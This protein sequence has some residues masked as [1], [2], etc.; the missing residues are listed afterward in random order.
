ML[1]INYISTL[2]YNI[3]I[4]TL[5]LFSDFMKRDLYSKILHR[6]SLFAGTALD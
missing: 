6:A 2:H 1:F 5:L 3:Y 4:I